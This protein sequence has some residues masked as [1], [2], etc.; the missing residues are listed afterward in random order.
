ME[1]R[2]LIE[3]LVTRMTPNATVVEVATHDRD[4]AITIAGTTGV[5]GQYFAVS[6]STGP[7]T[8]GFS[9]CGPFGTALRGEASVTSTFPLRPERIRRPGCSGVRDSD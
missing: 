8:F 1:P 2:R 3:A 4:Y 9:V 5:P 7:N 6:V